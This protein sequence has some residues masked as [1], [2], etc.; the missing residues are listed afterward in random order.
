MR[1]CEVIGNVTLSR[2]HPT[3]SGGRLLVA[4]PYSLADLAAKRP[5][6]GEELVIWDD[7]GAGTGTRVGVSEGREAAVPFHPE[8]KPIDAYCACILDSVELTT[9]G[10]GVFWR[11]PFSSEK[12]GF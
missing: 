1:I 11:S 9:D 6:S 2:G 4:A 7:L 10:S 8:R 3:I 5:P 12:T